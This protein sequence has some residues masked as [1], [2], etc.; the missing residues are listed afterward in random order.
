[1]EALNSP[2]AN[3]TALPYFMKSPGPRLVCLNDEAAR[4]ECMAAR[5]RSVN[6]HD[7]GETPKA[8]GRP[9]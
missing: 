6:E 5:L 1:A 8:R 7:N 2:A 3:I 4:H 9:Q